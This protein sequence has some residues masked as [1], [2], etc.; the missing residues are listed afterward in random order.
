MVHRPWLAEVSL[1]A[2]LGL[3][4][5]EREVLVHGTFQRVDV[6]IGGSA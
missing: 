3:C 5:S 1:A 2:A 6:G 4:A